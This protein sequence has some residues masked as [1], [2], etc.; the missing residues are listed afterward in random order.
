VV[1]K[2][3]M[4]EECGANL[5][6]CR[7][8]AQNLWPDQWNGDERTAKQ[9]GSDASRQLVLTRMGLFGARLGALSA[10]VGHAAPYACQGQD[11][12]DKDAMMA[13]LFC[14][15]LVARCRDSPE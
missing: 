12:A 4:E 15:E 5:A 13:W 14:R 2:K 3:D 6:P 1:S 7:P 11:L 8:N 9:L 10:A